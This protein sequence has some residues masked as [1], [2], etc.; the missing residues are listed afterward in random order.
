MSPVVGAS[1]V[2]LGRERI[3]LSTLQRRKQQHRDI[4]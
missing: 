4:E 3:V 2:N 1:V